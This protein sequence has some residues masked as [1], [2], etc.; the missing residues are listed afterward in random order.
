MIL[1]LVNGF[2]DFKQDT[3][4]TRHHSVGRHTRGSLSVDLIFA[5]PQINYENAVFTVLVMQVQKWSC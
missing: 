2:T 4:K 1:F 5:I 3:H